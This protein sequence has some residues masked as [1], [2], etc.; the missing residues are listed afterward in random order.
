MIK[1][2]NLLNAEPY[3]SYID[4]GH[5]DDHH[6]TEALEDYFR[7]QSLNRTYRMPSWMV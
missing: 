6:L 5:D 4:D 3:H 1:E 2:K 7:R